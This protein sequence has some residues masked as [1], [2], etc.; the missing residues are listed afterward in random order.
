MDW[1]KA[2]LL[3][4]LLSTFM[5]HYSAD[6]AAAEWNQGRYG[7]QRGE[8]L[9]IQDLDMSP[10]PIIEGQRVRA[11]KVRINFDGRRDCE[12]DVLIREGNNIVGH[13]RDYKMRPGVNEI[14]IPAIESFRYTGR[15][16]CFNVQIDLT[17]RAPR[18]TPPAVS[19]PASAPFGRCENRKTG[20]ACRL[21]KNATYK[22]YRGEN[23]PR[24]SP[25]FPIAA[26]H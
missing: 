23:R 10:D 9:N 19:A 2:A 12:T 24:G 11:W 21:G 26:H 22:R 1:I 7:C 8:R 5:P 16:H 14:E 15:E 17:A 18:S 20:D 13:A 6:L 4:G 3:T 25:S